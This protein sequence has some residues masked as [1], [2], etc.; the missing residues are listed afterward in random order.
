MNI[1]RRNFVKSSSLLYLASLGSAAF[2]TGCN[3]FDDILNWVPVGLT[4][5]QGIVTLLGPLVPPGAIT[6]LNLVKAAFADLVAAVNDYK[7]DTNPADKATLLAKIRTLL[8]DIVNHFQDFLN[9]LNL[10]NNPIVNIVIGLANIVISAIEG[11]MNQLP[12]PVSL[13]PTIHLGAQIVNITPK[14]YK[15]VGDFKKDYNA[16]ATANGHSEIV[17]H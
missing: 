7:N 1:T 6:I 8:N 12:P 4:A 3:V 9:A 13:V 11:F 5:I 16:F 17:I 2:I 10:G 15:H 14:Y